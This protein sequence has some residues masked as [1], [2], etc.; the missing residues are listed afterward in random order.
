MDSPSPFFVFSLPRSRSAWTAKWLSDAA[1]G[2]PVGHDLAIRGDTFAQ[3]MDFI[4]NSTLGTCETGLVEAAGLIRRALP[5][6]RFG[7]LQRN[8]FDVEAELAGIGAVLTAEGQEALA[9]RELALFELSCQPDVATLNWRDLSNPLL[10]AGFQAHLLPGIPFDKGLWA[11][12][13]RENVQVDWLEREALLR[14]RAAG[15]AGLKADCAELMQSWRPWTRIAFEPY[16][17]FAAEGE[18]LGASH[19][20]EA[21][22]G[23]AGAYQLDHRAIAE[24]EAAGTLWLTTARTDGELVGYCFWTKQLSVET[25]GAKVIEQGGFYAAPGASVGKRLLTFGLAAFARMGY[26]VAELHHTTHGRGARAGALY[27]RLGAKLEEKRYLLELERPNI[28]A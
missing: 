25:T 1:G 23:V 6:A 5:G 18:A 19:H 14:S 10:A 4:C 26:T 3:L 9:R 27:E 24:A 20:G 12:W 15:I 11:R 2:W 16:A 8:L 7:V 17:A 28:D 13:D 21:R 22:D